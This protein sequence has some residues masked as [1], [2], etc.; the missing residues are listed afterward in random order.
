M[1]RTSGYTGALA[2]SALAEDRATDARACHEALRAF[3]PPPSPRTA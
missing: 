2:W 3:R 1:A